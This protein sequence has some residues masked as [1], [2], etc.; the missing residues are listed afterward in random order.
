MSDW[1]EC[2]DSVPTE[3]LEEARRSGTPYRCLL[4]AGLATVGQLQVARSRYYKVPSLELSRYVPHPDSVGLLSEEQARKLKVLP[5]FQ[6]KD[7]LYLAI[8]D[9]EDLRTQDFVAKLTGMVVEPV[10]VLPEELE[11]ALNRWLLTTDR[12]GQFIQEITSA[13]KP[14][15]VD[16]STEAGLLEDREAPIIKLVDHMLSQAIRLG[17]SDVHLEAFETRTLLRYRIDGVLHEYPSP[18]K[19]IYA[20]VVSRIKITSGLDI[21][22]RRL[23]QDGR[24]SLVVDGRKYDL[25]VSVIPNLHG[26]GVVIRILNPYALK[27]DLEA[28]GFSKQLLERYQRLISKPYGI[29]LVTGPTGSGK[30][31]TLY[32]TLKRVTTL[33]KKVI[34]LEDPVEYQ[35]EGVTQI[36]IQPEIGYTFASGL[37]AILRHDPDIVLVGEMRDLES[38]QIAIR[39][40]LTGHQLYSTLHTNNAPQA[41]T[42]LVDMG[43]APYQVM[44]SLNGVL[45]QRLVRRLCDRCKV[46]DERPCTHEGLE[47]SPGA[48]LYRPGG[49]T[50]CHQLGYKGRVA[51]YELLELTPSIR[52]MDVARI[53]PEAI[54]A[55]ARQDNSFLSMARNAGEKLEQGITSLEEALTIVMED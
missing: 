15:A 24:S 44:A 47:V 55:L 33:E 23:P 34:T 53:T 6:V 35:L 37:K 30:S 32:S 40:A 45:A 13:A 52:A 11:Q 49:C 22:E 18:P 26:E 14:R 10:L 4:D 51:V 38:S 8:S 50:E 19:S 27:L 17:A 16:G 28:L 7:H 21:S 5:L 3:A 9:P 39:A 36:Q 41:I 2:L 42:R 1:L 46:V 25:R 29:V 12:A 43:V 48:T 20:G 54:V 31:T